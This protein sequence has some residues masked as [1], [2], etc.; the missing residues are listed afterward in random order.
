[1]DFN[2]VIKLLE[3]IGFVYDENSDSGDYIIFTK[4]DVTIKFDMT[5]TDKWSV[6]N[7]G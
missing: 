7:N 4:D 2:N 6:N 3:A 5:N 1:M